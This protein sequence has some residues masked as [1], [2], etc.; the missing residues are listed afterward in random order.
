MNPV[1]LSPWIPQQT[2][3]TQTPVVARILVRVVPVVVGAV[4]AALLAA[5][6]LALLTLTKEQSLACIV[7]VAAAAILGPSCLT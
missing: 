4:A 2:G 1:S 5:S 3:K 7:A 6:Q